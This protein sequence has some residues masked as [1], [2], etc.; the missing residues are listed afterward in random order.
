VTDLPC[1]LETTTV[2][3]DLDALSVLK[4]LSL[5]LIEQAVF[6]S[7]HANSQLKDLVY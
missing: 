1:A 7:Q 2:A 6:S 3:A 5:T 4:Q